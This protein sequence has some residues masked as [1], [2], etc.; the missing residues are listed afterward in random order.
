MPNA[1]AC[2]SADPYRATLADGYAVLRWLRYL[3][4]CRDVVPC[5]PQQFH[6]LIAIAESRRVER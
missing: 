2:T 5:T 6:R 1:S 4:F 3:R